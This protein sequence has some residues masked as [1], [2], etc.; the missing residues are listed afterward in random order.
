MVT[1]A[2]P[3]KEML[4]DL[5]DRAAEPVGPRLGGTHAYDPELAAQ[6]RQA[7]VLIGFTPEPAHPDPGVDLFLIQRSPLLRD[8]PGQIA[9]PGGRIDDSDAS[10]VAAALRETH[11][12]TG[13]SPDRIEVIGDLP[14][15]LVP[16]SSFVVTPVLGW[17]ED[18][19]SPEEVAPGEVLHTLR[20]PVAHLLDPDQR[21]AIAVAGFQAPRSAGFRLPSG[22]VW[23]FTG[24][25]LDHLFTELNWSRDWDLER[26]YTMTMDEARGARL[27]L[28][29][30]P[31][32]GP[33][34]ASG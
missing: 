20:V 12:E 13:L 21:S 2:H 3:A 26:R 31:D 24:N 25:L 7:A 19:G 23:G 1:A 34:P 9:L 8:H 10:P 33:N 11:E 15:V 14:P 29:P 22:W 6:Y 18:P 16:I 27:P 5:V 30:A 4:A 17:I 32:G 28:G